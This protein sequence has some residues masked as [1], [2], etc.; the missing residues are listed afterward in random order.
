M[1]HTGARTVDQARTHVPRAEWDDIRRGIAA[2]IAAAPRAATP[3]PL[4]EGFDAAAER[5]Y[6]A[7]LGMVMCARDK[8]EPLATLDEANAALVAYREAKASGITAAPPEGDDER[9]DAAIAAAFRVL[10]TRYPAMLLRDI[11]DAA[12]AV[13]AATTPPAPEGFRESVRDAIDRA[14]ANASVNDVDA[15]TDAVL[16]KVALWSTAAPPR[17]EP[18]L[19]IGAARIIEAY[20]PDAKLAL[21][22]AARL[23]AE[24]A[25]AATPPPAP[26][27][28]DG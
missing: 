22:Y 8:C 9:R 10:S 12:D 11:A 26:E 14:L 24:D 17:G 6:Q 19:L 20:A 1:A 21:D 18:G 28:Q 27:G 7:L 5:V 16:R 3:P 4:P 23:R 2:Y 13:L 25:R 15:A